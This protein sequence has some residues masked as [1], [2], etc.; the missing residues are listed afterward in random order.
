MNNNLKDSKLAILYVSQMTIQAE[1]HIKMYLKKPQG[2][3]SNIIGLQTQQT[4]ILICTTVHGKKN[5]YA[6]FVLWDICS[7]YKSLSGGP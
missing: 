1:P 6:V 3:V 5:K 2:E 7:H 4:Q